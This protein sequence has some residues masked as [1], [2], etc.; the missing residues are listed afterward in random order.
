[1]AWHIPTST[2]AAGA[3]VTM[4]ANDSVFI[5]RDVT[6]SSSGAAIVGN[7]DNV[8]ARIQGTVIGGAGAMSLGTIPGN[9]IG[10]EVIIER[11]GEILSMQGGVAVAVKGLQTSL[12]NAGLIFNYGGG[13]VSLETAGTVTS[14]TVV[15]SGT[16]KGTTWGFTRNSSFS[17]EKV[18]FTNSGLLQGGEKAYHGSFG[19]ET[20][21]IDLLTNT[22]RIIGVVDLSGGNDKYLGAAGRLTGKLFCDDGVDVAIGG[23]DNDWFEGGKDNDTLTGNSGNDTLRGDAGNDILNGGLGKDT[24]TGGTLNDTFKFT[25]LTHSKTGALA[26]IINDF[27]DSGNDRIDLSAV[28]G[29]KLVY[30]H[31]AAFTAVGQVRVNDVAGADVLVEVNTAG[32]LAADFVIRLKGTTLGS[33]T[34]T[35]F[36]L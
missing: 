2:S 13:G 28:Y 24:M 21:A 34:A 27:D 4:A 35:D 5:Y 23:I 31:G 16:I 30:K 36:V 19:S 1:M 17:T 10:P 25:A 29:P 9:G 20:V 32:S 22:G 3:V 11:G 6:I 33:M 7:V 18:V 26:D 12:N 14:S 8:F 15:N